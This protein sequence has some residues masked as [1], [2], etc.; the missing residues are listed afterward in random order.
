VV[1]VESDLL[2]KKE[3]EEEDEG[4]RRRVRAAIGGFDG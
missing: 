1:V 4:L 2:R 3:V